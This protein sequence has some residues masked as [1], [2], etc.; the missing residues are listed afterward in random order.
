MTE[1][2]YF[3]LLDSDLGSLVL[4]GDGESIT[5]LYNQDHPHF[6]A[7]QQGRPRKDCFQ[8]ALLQLNEYFRGE[9]RQFDLPLNPQGTSFQKTVWKAL[10]EIPFGDVCSYADIGQVIGKP[11][12]Y[13]AVGSANARNPIMIM[14]PCHRVIAANGALS[15]YSGGEQAKRWLLQH[16][17]SNR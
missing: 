6:E 11:K 10:T 8:S 4:T 9:R 7:S 13:R 5:G 15:G 3:T 14:I 16:E 12:A 1:K 17:Q 2:Q